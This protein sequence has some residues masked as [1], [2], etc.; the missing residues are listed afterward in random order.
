VAAVDA[1]LTLEGATGRV[2]EVEVSGP[3]GAAGDCVRAVL[4]GVAFP[5]FAAEV[6]VVRHRY[7]FETRR[8]AGQADAG[9]DAAT[10]R[11]PTQIDEHYPLDGTRETADA[12]TR[13]SVHAL[14]DDPPF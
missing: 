10:G 5:A 13:P 6:R 9:S 12:G 11:R 4:A 14:P 3:T 7:E 2:S 1:A 8:P